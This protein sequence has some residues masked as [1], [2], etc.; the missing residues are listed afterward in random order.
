MLKSERIA[1]D[2]NNKIELV[3]NREYARNMN[4]ICYLHYISVIYLV[5]HFKLCTE[6]LQI[7]KH[8]QQCLHFGRLDMRCIEM[9]CKFSNRIYHLSRLWYFPH[10]HTKHWLIFPICFC[11]KW[12]LDRMPNVHTCLFIN[13]EISE[14]ML[15]QCCWCVCL[16]DCWRAYHVFDFSLW[17]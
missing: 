5:N 14:S 7:L 13:H 11:S 9:F 10:V 3:L 8:C 4:L 15:S 12:C 16:T 1:K 17:P 6:F 2:A